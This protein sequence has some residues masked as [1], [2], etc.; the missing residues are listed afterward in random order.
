MMDKPM[1]WLCTDENI[2]TAIV[3]VGFG[4]FTYAMYLIARIS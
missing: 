2:A 3:V 1:D 4:V